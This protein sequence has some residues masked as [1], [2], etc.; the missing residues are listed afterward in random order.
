MR[1]AGEIWS[2]KKYIR[3]KFRINV[4]LN[5]IGVAYYLIEIGVAYYLIEIDVAYYLIEIDVAYYLIDV[6]LFAQNLV[7]RSIDAMAP[8]SKVVF[9]KVAALN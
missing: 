5:E 8:I 6:Q 1:Q 3:I 4:A 2:V 7:H 9:L